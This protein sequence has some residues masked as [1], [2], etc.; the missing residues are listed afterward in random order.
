[1]KNTTSH[2]RACFVCGAAALMLLAA[3]AL[4]APWRADSSRIPVYQAGTLSASGHYYVTRDITVSTA[5]G[6]V[7]GADHV[8][9]DLNG[10]RLLGTYTSDGS[11]IS[12]NGHSDIRITNGLVQGGYY[13]IYLYAPGGTVRIDDLKIT[14]ANYRALAVEGTSGNATQ[15]FLERN[16]IT[17]AADRGIHLSYAHAGQI[18][19]NTVTGCAVGI[20]MENSFGNILR[21]NTFASNSGAGITLWYCYDNTVRANVACKNGTFL[22]D[23]G[24]LLYESSNNTIDYNMT[25]ENTNYGLYIYNG[26]GNVFAYNH[27]LG[28]GTGNWYTQPP[29]AAV[30]G[31]GN[32]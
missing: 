15:V 24:I 28:N 3:S 23:S 18:L 17:G 27:V 9:L 31:G 30:N 29:S 11:I 26:G 5:S 21:G 6:I 13:G 12:A 19:D 22:S 20:R 2:L 32:F 1:M 10:H 8:T 4:E 25:S 7:I 16:L 14:G